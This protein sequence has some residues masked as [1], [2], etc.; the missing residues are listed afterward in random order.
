M[1]TNRHGQRKVFV[2]MDSGFFGPLVDPGIYTVKLTKGDKTYTGTITLIKDP[3]SQ[4]TEEDIA[5]Q[6]KA[7]KDVFT[8]TEDLAFFNHQVLGMIDSTK[9]E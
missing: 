1:R 3:L 2:R 5:L 4:H 7:S 9:A 8:L 6:R